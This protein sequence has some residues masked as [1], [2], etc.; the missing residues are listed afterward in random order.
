[1]RSFWQCSE[2]MQSY[3]EEGVKVFCAGSERMQRYPEKV[4][5]S[6]WQ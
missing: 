4:V 1:M 3:P 2:H 6:F 5:G